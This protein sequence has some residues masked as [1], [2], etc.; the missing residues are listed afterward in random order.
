MKLP[1]D[2][3]DL[4]ADAVRARFDWARRQ[5]HP[6]WLWPNV[7]L[8]QW[9]NALRSI[10]AATRSV[11]SDAN[12]V[13]PLRYSDLD[14][15]GVACYTSGM[16]P[17]LGWWRAEGRIS[18]DDELSALLEL[19]LDHHRSRS[20]RMQT[21]TS[22]LVR[23]LTEHSIPVAIFKGADTALRYFPDPATRPASDIDLLVSPSRAREAEQLLQS[24]GF[25]VLKRSL[26]ES[27]WRLATARRQ[28]RS[29]LL[30][31]ADDPWSVD[32]HTSLDVTPGAG[33][34]VV[35]F[36]QRSPIQ[37]RQHEDSG[38]AL[39][40]EQ[41]LLLLYLAAHAGSGLHNLTL[42]R[43]VEL[44][45]VVRQDG[46]SGTLHWPTF[47][48]NGRDLGALGSAWPAL[49]LAD[50][51]L[52]GTI[53]DA[54][55]RECALSAPP[56][57]RRVVGQLEPATAQRLGDISLGEHFMWSSG[58]AGMLRQLVAD[59]VPSRSWREV[60]RVY[61]RRMWQLARGRLSR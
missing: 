34:R 35:P 28:P 9:R 33:A 47:L 30:V 52:P 2:V 42:L 26:R 13:A 22:E 18:A 29:L 36:D 48:A 5:G 16:G 12:A 43:L 25:E 50:Q 58:T 10:E 27:E 60:S 6:S 37:R 55:L 45:F 46:A 1:F 21:A 3:Y 56:R 4:S 23:G 40:L 31:H 39:Q 11:L 8:E 19:H 51:L 15:M 49:K 17:L 57:V 53:P 41:P 61:K 14:A 44:V 54:V 7:P 20:R 32:L 24:R 38:S 59:V